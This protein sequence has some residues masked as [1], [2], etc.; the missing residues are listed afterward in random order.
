MIHHAIFGSVVFVAITWA[1]YEVI[2]GVRF[3]RKR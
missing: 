2:Q 3:G 1:V